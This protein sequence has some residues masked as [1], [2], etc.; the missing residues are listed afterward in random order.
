MRANG[1]ATCEPQLFERCIEAVFCLTVTGRG[2]SIFNLEC[3]DLRRFWYFFSYSTGRQKD[4][5]GYE[6]NTKAA[7]IAA[8][9]IE[10]CSS[11]LTGN[12]WC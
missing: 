6:K 10:I 5:G 7:K 8:L 11:R 2:R 1:A 9:Q 12:T 4:S 3:G